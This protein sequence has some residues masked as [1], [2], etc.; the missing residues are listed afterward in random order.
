MPRMVEGA[1]IEGTGGEALEQ[2]GWVY[3][4]LRDEIISGRL[5]PT[6]G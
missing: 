4:R 1:T 6:A 2:P 5:E 3:E